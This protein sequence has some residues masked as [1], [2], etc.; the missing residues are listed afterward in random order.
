MQP[1][2]WRTGWGGGGMD[3][4]RQSK[5]AQVR[6]PYHSSCSGVT[7][8]WRLIKSWRRFAHAFIDGFLMLVE[9]RQ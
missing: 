8:S 5:R 2:S 7:L 6:P 3:R 4:E 1:G 9:C